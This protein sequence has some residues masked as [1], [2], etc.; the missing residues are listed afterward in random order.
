MIEHIAFDD[1]TN[2]LWVSFRDSGRYAYYG[3]PATLFDTFCQAG[4]AGTVFN[5]QVKGR[6]HWRRDP[7]RRRFGPNA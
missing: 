5:E 3:V 2:T 6:F 1:D 4:S 7:E